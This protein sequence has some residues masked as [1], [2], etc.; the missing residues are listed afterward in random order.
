LINFKSINMTFTPDPGAEL[1]RVQY[2]PPLWGVRMPATVP[3]RTTAPGLCGDYR[4][5]L[6][7]DFS[8]PAQIR[9]AGSYPAGCGE[10]V[11]P[12]AYS[13]PASYSARAVR[14]LWQNMGGQLTGSVREGLAPTTSATFELVSPTLAEVIRD[15]NKFSN[16]VMAEQ[17]FLT[18]GRANAGVAGNTATPEAARTVLRRWWLQRISMP[19]PEIPVPTLDNGSGLSRQARISAHA[20]ARL[21]QLSYASPYQSE[22][23]SSLPIVGLDGTLK[24]STAASASAHLKTGSLQNV[25]ALA[26]FVHG[27]N[28]H[29]WALVAL[30]NHENA[31]A[32]RP[33]MDAL[34]DWA[35]NEATRPSTANS[36]K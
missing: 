36:A 35:A 15:I 26:G 22:L 5:A 23:M 4:G 32:A 8:D 30:I 21:L 9:F 28:G 10:K 13:D 1:V 25:L 2:D 17:L 14:G 6:Q 29:S 34:V 31:S 18:L 19:N 27:S 3:L 7:A 20:L 33:A 11:W 12:L 16:N 24:R